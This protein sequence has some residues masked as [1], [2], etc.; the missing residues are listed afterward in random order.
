MGQI[1]RALAVAAAEGATASASDAELVQRAEAGDAAAFD[2]LYR[3]HLGPV[4]ACAAG[5]LRNR[6]EA[7]EV[8]QDT[9]LTAWQRLS[10]FHFVD[11]SAL[12]WLLVTCRYKS[13]NRHKQLQRRDRHHSSTPLDEATAG[14]TVDD[15][16]FVTA[17]LTASINDAVSQ[18]SALDRQVYE[19]CFVGGMTYTDAAR[20]MG[21]SDGAVRNRLSRLRSRL[22]SELKTLKGSS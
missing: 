15:D 4:Y 16:T 14:T 10:A 17:E 11:Q 3:R 5:I 8:V 12:P 18:L 2:E 22:R 7:E 6:Q 20:S 1:S 9:F 13:L 21:A 19:L